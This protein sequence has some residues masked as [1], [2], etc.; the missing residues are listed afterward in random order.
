MRL[1]AAAATIRSAAQSC[2]VP[3][4]V[5]CCYSVY[6]LKCYGGHGGYVC[7][8]LP[9]EDTRAR[10]EAHGSDMLL[11]LIGETGLTFS[12]TVIR[13]NISNITLV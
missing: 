2:H 3:V 6:L 5:Q 7:V 4:H 11:D 9:A 1:H 13:P 12:R 10:P 8:N